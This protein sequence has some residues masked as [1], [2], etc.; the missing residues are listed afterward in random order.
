MSK[1]SG[2]RP[3][4]A[5]TGMN[6]WSAPNPVG[7][8]S[9][10][11]GKPQVNG[12]AGSMGVFTGKPE[13][14]GGARSGGNI[15][16]PSPGASP[17]A[18]SGMNPWANPQMSAHVGNAP[19]GSFTGKP[20]VNGG[21]RSG[22]VPMQL[23][24]Q[25]GYGKAQVNVMPQMGPDGPMMPGPMGVPIPRQMR[26]MGGQTAM[27]FQQQNQMG[28]QQPGPQRLAQMPSLMGYRR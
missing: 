18:P 27:R 4:G 21:A 5:M 10:F 25:G 14:N 26:G 19:V 1:G 20:E 6:P 15:G 16:R 17:F 8:S 23:P 7:G 3:G 9:A 12:G 22:G 11:T 28:A 24:P 2:G 13:I